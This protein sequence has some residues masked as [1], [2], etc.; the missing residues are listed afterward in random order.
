MR[1]QYAIVL[2]NE[3]GVLAGEVDPLHDM[4]VAIRRLRTLLRVLG[5]LCAGRAAR[6]MEERLDVLQKSLG[7]A[8]DA[9]VL[10]GI[11]QSKTICRLL[12]GLSAREKVLRRQQSVLEERKETVRTLLRGATY[13][14]LK[15]DMA[16]F[17]ETNWAGGNQSPPDLRNTAAEA[18]RKALERVA[19]RSDIPASSPPEAVHKLRI[20]CRR[21]RYL[22]EF[23]APVLG[24]E[25]ATLG[26][27]LKQMQ[28]LLGDVHDLDVL[29]AELEREH[30]A[31]P[32]KLFDAL[33][34]RRKRL[35]RKLRKE[36]RGDGVTGR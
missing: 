28:D 12:E 18:I 17:L 22:C 36:E 13:R 5:R 4:R 1:E 14:R 10:I 7:P 19:R 3:K 33:R 31:L 8:R 2:T 27:R 25:T 32:E 26:E 15:N 35:L 34:Q 23:F 29:M 9:D 16:R 30:V 6:R 20:A 21:A 24:P 11:L